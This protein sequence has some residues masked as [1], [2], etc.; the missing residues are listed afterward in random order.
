MTSIKCELLTMS[1][2]LSLSY[3]TE[4]QLRLLRCHNGAHIT[5]LVGS[6]I[7]LWL[8]QCVR[9]MNEW[10]ILNSLMQNT[11]NSPYLL[12]C[13]PSCLCPCPHPCP[14]QLRASTPQIA[15]RCAALKAPHGVPRWQLRTSTPQKVRVGCKVPH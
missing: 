9:K 6:R 14:C 13:R 7:R 12:P 11:K 15:R 3:V 4:S 8:L 1:L 10:S 2:S 5:H